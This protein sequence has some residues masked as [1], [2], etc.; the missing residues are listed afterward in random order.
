MV[1]PANFA[2]T[3]FTAD[4][5]RALVSLERIAKTDA[6]TLL[7]GH[8][9]P[10]RGGAE[11]AVDEARRTLIVIHPPSGRGP[12]SITGAERPAEHGPPSALGSESAKKRINTRRKA[13]K[14][15]AVGR[16]NAK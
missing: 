1:H 15:E 14:I 4:S 16:G 2:G 11:R 6:G 3:A 13:P 9:E 10:W 12:Y 8:G 7:P 5:E